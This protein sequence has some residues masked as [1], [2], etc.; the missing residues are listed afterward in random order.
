[1]EKI[2]IIF[3]HRGKK[4]EGYFIRVAESGDSSTRHL[5]DKESYNLGRLRKDA[6]DEWIFDESSPKD[7]LKYL[8]R[9]FGN[10]VAGNRLT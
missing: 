9:F 10:F 5:Y 6:N 7:E 3:E 8:A 1:M 4:F 2:P